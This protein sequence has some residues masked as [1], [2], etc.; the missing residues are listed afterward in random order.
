MS[1]HG[2]PFLIAVGAVFVAIFGGYLARNFAPLAQPQQ[3]Q[4]EQSRR[5]IL[6]IVRNQPGLP[7]LA[8][9]IST[10]CPSIGAIAP[11][12]ATGSVAS[13]FAI[14][15]DGWVVVGPRRFQKASWKYI[16]SAG[17]AIAVT[18]ERS[19]PVSGLG[20][21]K[22]DTTGLRPIR[23]ADQAFPRVGDFGFAIDNP[24]AAGCSA[25]AAM[26]ASDFLTDGGA[27]TAY[28]RLQPMGADLSS[29]DPFISGTGEVIGVVAGTVLPDTVISGDIVA[30]IADELVRGSLSP[31][32][33]F[34]FRAEDFDT[35]LAGRLERN[36]AQPEPR[37]RWCSQRLQP[38]VPGSRRETS[39]SA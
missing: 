13:G 15:G 30:D 19:D 10:L 33:H 18:E 36:P 16:F 7:S 17:P 1:D 37:S 21:I 2:D 35:A 26:I 3:L 11:A 23:L 22:T 5:P 12:G 39:L 9:T 8:D 29:G 32:T 6:Q 25:Q 38:L 20:I 4:S 24:A 31:T 34:G 14:S 28:I 27:P